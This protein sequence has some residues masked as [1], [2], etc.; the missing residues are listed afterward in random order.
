MQSSFAFSR[1]EKETKEFRTKTNT[2]IIVKNRSMST[3]MKSRNSIEKSQVLQDLQSFLQMIATLLT[4]I[5]AKEMEVS[6]II[7]N[8]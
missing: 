3:G 4:T 5:A 7:T 8:L 2:Q 6:V 1:K